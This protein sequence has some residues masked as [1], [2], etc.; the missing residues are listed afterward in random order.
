MDHGA[1]Q[2]QKIRKST[3]DVSSMFLPEEKQSH[4]EKEAGAQPKGDGRTVVVVAIGGSRGAH[5]HTSRPRRSA[6]SRALRSHDSVSLS[7]LHH[8]LE[9]GILHELGH[10]CRISDG[11]GD[12]NLRCLLN[13]DVTR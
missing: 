10:D 6:F 1:S 13:D 5:V 11:N 12:A 9:G 4:R 2:E 7:L 8:G 3:Q